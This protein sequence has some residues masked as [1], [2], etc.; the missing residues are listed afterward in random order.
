MG[1]DVEP[2]VYSYMESLG[3]AAKQESKVQKD[4]KTTDDILRQLVSNSTVVSR[5]FL[6]KT[7]IDR[8]H[9]LKHKIQA[10]L[11]FYQTSSSSLILGVRKGAHVRRER[12][13]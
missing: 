1:H 8:L 2:N 10:D 6:V 4:F 5:A 12:F 3:A 9:I 11:D 7:L 13:K